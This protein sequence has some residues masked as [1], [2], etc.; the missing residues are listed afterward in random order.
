MIIEA[1]DG[2]GNLSSIG[3]TVPTKHAMVASN[4]ESKTK[5]PMRLVSNRA[6]APGISN[7]APTRTAPTIFTA[8]IVTKSDHHDKQVVV[9]AGV[10]ATNLGNIGANT[11]Q[12]NA[13]ERRYQEQNDD[14][15]AACENC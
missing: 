15:A 14:R 4:A 3:K 8:A 7:N 2:T 11:S 13:V 1:P 6:V 10:I 9:E 5:L 12:K